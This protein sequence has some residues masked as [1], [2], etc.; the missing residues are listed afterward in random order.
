MKSMEIRGKLD[1]DS[2]ATIFST[3][4]SDNEFQRSYKT[5]NIE[6]MVITGSRYFL[7]TS[8]MVGFCL[9]YVYDGISTRLDFGRVGG[10]SG[11]LGIRLGAGDKA[12]ESMCDKIKQL[13]ES[14]GL[15]VLDQS[16]ESS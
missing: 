8:D 12:E 15:V 10:G 1:Q 9:F 6:I 16:G 3:E 11:L 14:E 5:Q 13:A 7:R 4:I 2:V